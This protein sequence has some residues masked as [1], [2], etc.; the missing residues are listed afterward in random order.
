MKRSEHNDVF[1]THLNTLI[2][3]HNPWARSVDDKEGK[4]EKI[5]GTCTKFFSRRLSPVKTTHLAS[6]SVGSAPGVTRHY[7]KITSKWNK[8]TKDPEKKKESEAHNSKTLP[9]M[10]TIYETRILSIST[11]VFSDNT[12]VKKRVNFETMED[13]DTTRCNV[14]RS[15]ISA[16]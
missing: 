14:D 13:S 3:S 9:P 16:N 8:P 5:S 4:G 15:S 12:T 7:C 6:S 1:A 10:N 2:G 11:K